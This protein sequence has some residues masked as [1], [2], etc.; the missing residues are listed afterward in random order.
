MENQFSY[1]LFL[2]AAWLYAAGVFS[3]IRLFDLAPEA[4]LRQMFLKKTPGTKTMVVV[5]W[6]L[7]VILVAFFGSACRAGAGVVRWV[8]GFTTWSGDGVKELPESENSGTV[9]GSEPP[10]PE[11]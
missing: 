9:S 3:A 10:E 4:V 11:E 2:A 7:F 6:P 5:F 8:C 1:I